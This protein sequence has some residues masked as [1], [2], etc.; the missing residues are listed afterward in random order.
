MST[1]PFEASDCGGELVD[2]IEPVE[3]EG[4]VPPT[5]GSE[6]RLGRHRGIDRVDAEEDLE[7]GVVA[8]ELVHRSDL[9]LQPLDER[10]PHH[11]RVERAERDRITPDESGFEHDGHAGHSGRGRAP[12]PAASGNGRHLTRPNVNL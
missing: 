11:A 4:R 3:R 6:P 10:E 8:L 5:A 7:P 12:S 9:V 2:V 1:R